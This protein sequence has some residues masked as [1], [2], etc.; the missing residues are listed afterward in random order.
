MISRQPAARSSPRHRALRAT[1]ITG[2]A[3]TARRAI[4]H[5]RL[6]R[7]R[8]PQGGH[9]ARS[10]LAVSAGGG[11]RRYLP[12]RAVGRRVGSAPP[13][14]TPVAVGLRRASD[15]KGGSTADAG[16]A[17]RFE[18]PWSAVGRTR[19]RAPS[20]SDVAG[21]R[22]SGLA[23]L[24]L[25]RQ[26]SR[27][28]RPAGEAAWWFMAVRPEAADNGPR[29]PP[30]PRCF[31]VVAPGRARARPALEA[32]RWKCRVKPTGRS[33]PSSLLVNSGLSCDQHRGLGNHHAVTAARRGTEGGA[34]VGP[35]S[36]ER[37]IWSRKIVVRSS[38]HGGGRRAWSSHATGT[39]EP[40]IRLLPLA[41][42]GRPWRTIEA[43][44]KG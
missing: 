41:V 12:G 14:P 40:G 5:H 36:F 34:Q 18:E 1:G 44:S 31:G 19:G 9:P 7:W 29:R 30:P 28:R 21:A 15:G 27:R 24:V 39:A 32:P 2:P 20:P 38:V 23:P 4:V 11:A 3:W 17:R 33:P 37:T 22:R 42:S 26:G 25:G 43:G 8:R 13:S 10:G 6:A 16:T 35:P